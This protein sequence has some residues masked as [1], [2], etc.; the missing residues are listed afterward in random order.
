[1]TSDA[2]VCTGARALKRSK[3]GSRARHAERTDR[4]LRQLGS[5]SELRCVARV[6][7]I[8]G[9]VDEKREEVL[10]AQAGAVLSIEVLA[11][12]GDT[13]GDDAIS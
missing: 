5:A 11:L 6:L 9:Q 3:A 13:G 7:A 4:L 8:E 10:N 2:R 12:H 1:M